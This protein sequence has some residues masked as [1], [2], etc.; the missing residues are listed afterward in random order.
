[1]DHAARAGVPA[2][3]GADDADP[4]RLP[5]FRHPLYP[6]GDPRA[7]ALIAACPLPALHAEFAARVDAE[8][9]EGPNVDFA[10]VALAD[11]FGL[12]PEAPFVVFM[13]ARCAGWLAH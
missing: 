4:S 6:D 2:A 10:L 5:G 1:L 11:G 3:L 7:A 9:G 8:H 12:P 13:L